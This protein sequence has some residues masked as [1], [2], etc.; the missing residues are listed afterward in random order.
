MIGKIIKG[1]AGFYYVQCMN[2]NLYECK[3]RG[4][5]R[6]KK[7]KPLVGDNVEIEILDEEKLL[8]SI[9]EVLPR[10]SCLLRPEVAN[11]DQAVIIFA[12]RTPEPNFNLL[13]RFLIRMEKEEV[14]AIICF[15]K[16]ELVSQQEQERLTGI[17][18]ESGYQIIFTS[19]YEEKGL[20]ELSELLQNKTTVV[21]GPSGVGKSS[22]INCLCR[23][24]RM[25]TGEISDKIKRGRHTTRHSELFLVDKNTYIMD[26][27]GFTSLYLN[28][29][30]H[31]DLRFYFNEFSIYEGKCRFNGCVHINEPD[32]AVKEAVNAGKISSVRYENYTEIYNELK[33]IRRY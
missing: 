12:V 11:V 17:F 6:N 2:D 29:F 31:D 24:K 7:I 15:N 27:P 22:I 23:E 16:E 9:K 21:A 20:K 13:T 30:H 33:S 8:G 28:E 3:A 26:T 4:N 1:I 25:E 5:F 32:C 19:T 18:A 14:P 10:N